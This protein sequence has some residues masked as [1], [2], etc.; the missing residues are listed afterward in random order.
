MTVRLVCLSGEV[1]EER[2]SLRARSQRRGRSTGLVSVSLWIAKINRTR[3]RLSAKLRLILSS[4]FKQVKNATESEHYSHVRS[5]QRFLALY[6]YWYHTGENAAIRQML[7]HI[8][9]PEFV[10]DIDGEAPYCPEA[11]V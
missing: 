9:L 4:E 1:G 11:S 2:S 5:L 3:S 10:G 7:G 8:N 6:H